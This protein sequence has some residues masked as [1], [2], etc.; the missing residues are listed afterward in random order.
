MSSLTRRYEPA[1]PF[2]LDHTMWPLTHGNGDPTCIRDATGWW[3]AS[4]TPGGPVTLRLVQRRGVIEAEAWGPGAEWRLDSLPAMLGDDDNPEGLDP[5]HDVVH[6]LQRRLRGLRFTRTG[7]VVETL[8]PTIVEQLVNGK[9]ARRSFRGLVRRWGEPAPGPPGLM[10]APAPEVL[11]GLPYYEL[12]TL[13]IERRR[14]DL[15]RAVGLHARR[16]EEAVMMPPAEADRRLRAL[17]GIGAWTSAAVRQVALGDPDAVK[18]ADYH[19]PHAV[20]WAL[21]GEPRCDDR[22]MLELLEPYAGQRARVVRLLET[23]G[24]YAPRYG[25]RQPLAQI[26]RL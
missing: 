19:L 20:S 7:L 10:L 26:A 12:H 3:I 21:A 15:L 25:P 17:P 22:R 14:A 1:H 9:E 5:A 24:L 13:G 2:N 6:D 4:R 23:A 8:V 18:L 16:L 11:A